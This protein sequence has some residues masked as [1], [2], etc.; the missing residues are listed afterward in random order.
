MGFF[1]PNGGCLLIASRSPGKK[2]KLKPPLDKFQDTPLLLLLLFSLLLSIIITKIISFTKNYFLYLLPVLFVLR[3]RSKNGAPRQPSWMY[4]APNHHCRN[5]Y[6][7]K[8]KKSFKK[9]FPL[10]LEIFLL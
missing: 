4:T 2:T 5:G 8:I 7:L 6:L 9:L 1:G 3:T 10:I